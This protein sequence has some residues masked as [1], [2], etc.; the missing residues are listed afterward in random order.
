MN[1]E[2]TSYFKRGLVLLM[3]VIMVFTYMPG[4]TWGAD[5]AWAGEVTLKGSG[6]EVD[7]YLIES[8][9]DF[10]AMSS[11]GY[12]KLTKDITVETPYADE[13]TGTFDGDGHTV[14]LAIKSGSDYVGLFSKLGSS[15]VVKNICTA[16]EVNGG[17]YVGGIAGTSTGTIKCCKNTATVSATSR[18]VGGIAGKSTGKIENSYNKGT[19][20]STRT[21][22]A[23]LGGIVGN[24]ENGTIENCYNVGVITTSSTSNFASVAGWLTAATAINCYYL[25]AGTLTGTNEHPTANKAT[26]K[27]Q[28]DMKSTDFVTLLNSNN[29]ET[30]AFMVKAGDYPALKWETPTA[31]VNFTISPANATLT[32]TKSGDIAATYTGK[33][34]TV[35]LPAGEYSYT[36]SCEGYTEQS[37]TVTVSPEQANTGTT[38][39]AIDVTLQEDSN[40]WTTVAFTLEP[41]TATFV[42]KD[43]D[44]VLTTQSGTTY[45]VLKNKTYTYTA[46]ADGYEDEDGSYCY[47]T[48][49]GSCSISLKKVT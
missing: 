19:V 2:Q 22:A 17:Q 23:H 26:K 15:A 46:T 49:G 20:S 12:S 37:G 4:G 31:S 40:Q 24:L 35:A 33:G 29:N 42:L 47:D 7:P 43:G 32:I 6:T 18:Y 48:N 44:S 30:G 41:N 10:A 16:G 34:G 25:E 1:N 38:L 39:G 8:A 36:V 27:T 14:T 45:K 3:A 9:N 5:T 11:S 28:E 13:F 21:G